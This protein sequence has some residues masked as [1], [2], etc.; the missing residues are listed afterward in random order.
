MAF[1]ANISLTYL[2][3]QGID[4][5]ISQEVDI[6]SMA[7]GFEN[8]HQPLVEAIGRAHARGILI[9]SAASN[10]RNIDPVYCPAI[11]TDQVFGMFSTNAGVRESTSIN[12]SPL[13]ASVSFAIFG[14]DV[15][16]HEDGPLL[17]GTSYSTSIGAGVAAALL[18]FSR[19][20][21]D[22]N[23]GRLSGLRGRQQMKRVLLE[24]STPD[25]NYK[26]IRPWSLLKTDAR[27]AEDRSVQREW[28]RGTIERLLQPENLHGGQRR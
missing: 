6:I 3:E 19:Q 16:I 8:E 18:D 10:G 13:D 24:M 1:P 28:I 25:G 12:P 7:I 21:H 23:I 20:G 5:A 14:E 15:E 26:C 11:I 2:S 9:F 27:Q 22:G 17:K 4:W